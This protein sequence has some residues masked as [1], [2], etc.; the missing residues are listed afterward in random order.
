MGTKPEEVKKLLNKVVVA[1][2][3]SPH[4]DEVR[5]QPND[6]LDF[7][8]CPIEYTCIDSALDE[9]STLMIDLFRLIYAYIVLYSCT[10]LP[11]TVVSAVRA[12]ADPDGDL[13]TAR[14]RFDKAQHELQK[15]T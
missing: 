5:L 14:M 15:K 10:V 8:Q 1:V 3:E 11:E 13:I 6:V 9:R 2:K 4:K 7:V 12:Y